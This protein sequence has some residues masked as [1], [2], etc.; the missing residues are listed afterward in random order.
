MPDYWSHCGY[1]HLSVSADNRLIVGDDF[2]RADLLR[3]ELSPIPASC[4][5]ELRLHDLMLEAPRRAVSPAEIDAIA[6]ADVRDNLRIWLRFRDRLL[7]ADTLEAAYAR[8]F[9]GDGVDVAPLFVHRLTE[10]IVRHVL[11][12]SAD[13]LEARMA[14]LLFRVQFKYNC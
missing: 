14:E 5:A 7:A 2:L 1:R 9:Q 4:D 13:P 6:D 3:P 12:A 10:V 11:G 8:L